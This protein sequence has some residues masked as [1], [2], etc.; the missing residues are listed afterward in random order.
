MN[1][2]LAQEIE[3]REDGNWYIRYDWFPAPLPINLEAADKVY[4][5]TSYSFAHFHSKVVKGFS[6]GYASGN[7]LHCRFHAGENGRIEVGKYVI[8]E[9]TNIISGKL[10][11]IGD[12]CMFSW[13]S[14]LTDSWLD[15]D[16]Y[17]IEKRKTMLRSM[18]ETRD[19]F[20][21][22]ENPK[23]VIIE[24]NVWVGFDAVILPGVRIG[25][26]AV[27]AAKTVIAQDVL[28]YAVMAGNPA[29]VIK[30][31]EPNDTIEIQQKAIQ[32]YSA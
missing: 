2:N 21:A 22:F 14:F 17:S 20:L 6:I 29:R 23:P 19:R 31:L 30:F 18:A 4:L 1:R 24:D 11:R 25:R 27:I 28:P 7:Y 12:H 5:D 16:S 3:Q 8:L 15:Q 26:G 9:S 13:G 10:V 32:E